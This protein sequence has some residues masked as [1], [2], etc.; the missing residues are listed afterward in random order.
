MASENVRREMFAGL[1]R[2]HG[3]GG[4]VTGALALILCGAFLT[5]AVPTRSSEDWL[6]DL[7]AR[8]DQLTRA[9][10]ARSQAARADGPSARAEPR[11]ETRSTAFAS[12]VTPAVDR[13]AA[14]A[15]SRAV[16]CTKA[17]E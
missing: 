3:F 11:V 5:D 2:R 16:R 6:Y 12:I 14:P 15:P 13:R 4:V 17:I 8:R 9:Y 7:E 10:H 1:P